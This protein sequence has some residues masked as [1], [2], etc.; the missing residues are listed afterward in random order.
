MNCPACGTPIKRFDLAPNCKKCGVSILY[1][2]QEEDLKKDAKKAELEFAKARAVVGKIKA[3]YVDSGLVIARLVVG[4]LSLIVF[5]VPFIK[6]TINLPLVSTGFSTGIIGIYQLISSG[7]WQQ[8][9]NMY[10]SG[11]GGAVTAAVAAHIVCY[12]FAVLMQV[13]NLVTMLLAA[14]DIRRGA[15][16]LAIFSSF[17]ALGGIGALVSAIIANVAA[18]DSESINVM[19]PVGAPLFLG[20]I[21]AFLVINVKLCKNTPAYVTPELDVKRIEMLNK[22]KAGEIKLDDLP[23]PVFESEEERKK[24]ENLFGEIKNDKKEDK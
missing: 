17:A 7:M 1:F 15:K 11:V 16:T 3:T 2:S 20:L 6:L 8:L 23:L 22:L 18:K 14:I 5:L 13:C 19:F 9:L 4:L 21:I 24:R 10:S 12:V